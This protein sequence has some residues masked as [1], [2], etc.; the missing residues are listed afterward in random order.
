M[1]I[2]RGYQHWVRGQ[3]MVRNYVEMVQIASDMT[4]AFMIC[5]FLSRARSSV[6]ELMVAVVFSISSSMDVVAMTAINSKF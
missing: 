4:N 3:I 5:V 6:Y 1:I 2:L